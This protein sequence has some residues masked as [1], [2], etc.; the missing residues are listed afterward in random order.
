MGGALI[1]IVMVFGWIDGETGQ[2]VACPQDF[3]FNVKSKIGKSLLSKTVLIEDGAISVDASQP[4][5]SHR[6][7]HFVLAERLWGNAF[8]LSLLA[9]TE[10]H[11]AFS[12]LLGGVEIEVALNGVRQQIGARESLNLYAGVLPDWKW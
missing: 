4:R 3:I 1:C 9:R 12:G 2:A 6:V 11:Y 8:V 7:S 10:H 5:I